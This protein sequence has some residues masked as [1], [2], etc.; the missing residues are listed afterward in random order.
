MNVGNG[1]EAVF[2][3]FHFWEYLFRNFRYTVFAVLTQNGY[4]C[5]KLKK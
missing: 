2:F 3:Q 1:T 5:E 4:G